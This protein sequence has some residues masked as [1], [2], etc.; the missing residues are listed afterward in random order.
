ML[1]I[2][3]MVRIEESKEWEG[4]NVAFNQL[5][6]IARRLKPRTGKKFPSP[7]SEVCF[8]VKDKSSSMGVLQWG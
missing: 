7:H 5:G 2:M 6:H 3:P 1:G 4:R 8:T